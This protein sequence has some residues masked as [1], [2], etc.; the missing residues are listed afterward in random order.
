MSRGEVGSV[1]G[2]VVTVVLAGVTT[3]AIGEFGARQYATLL[4]TVGAVVAMGLAA[5]GLWREYML[6]TGFACLVSVMILQLSLLG[7]VPIPEPMEV[8]REVVQV[9]TATPPIQGRL[10]TGFDDG[11]YPLSRDISTVGCVL[12]TVDGVAV[13]DHPEDGA[14]ECRIQVGTDDYQY[15]ALGSLLSD[16]TVTGAREDAESFLANEYVTYF[17][18]GA[19]LVVYCG[20]RSI[21]QELSGYMA[22]RLRNDNGNLVCPSSTEF[23][24]D[25]DGSDGVCE[26]KFA[27]FVDLGTDEPYTIEL[28]ANPTSPNEFQCFI[29]GAGEQFWVNLTDTNVAVSDLSEAKFERYILTAHHDDSRMVYQLDSIYEDLTGAE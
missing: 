3:V 17:D 12:N 27:H 21:N 13:M 14:S 28:R 2:L 23:S 15:M 8:T 29:A 4:F 5:Y 22:V 20:V 10:V 7:G 1:I 26:M 19:S 9:V 25:H 18:D 16:V 6:P 11:T 24:A